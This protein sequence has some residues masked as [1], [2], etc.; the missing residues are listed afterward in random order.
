MERSARF[1]WSFALQLSASFLSSFFG[2]CG[3]MKKIAFPAVSG[4]GDGLTAGMPMSQLIST[5]VFRKMIYAQVLFWGKN[6][7]NMT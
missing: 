3:T 1:F 6:R 5:I 7:K 2:S 4:M